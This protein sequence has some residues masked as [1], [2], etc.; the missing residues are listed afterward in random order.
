[1]NISAKGTLWA[2]QI[3]AMIYSIF[4]Q[5]TWF[6]IW[7]GDPRLGY[8]LAIAIDTGILAGIKVSKRDIQASVRPLHLVF[9]FCAVSW[10]ANIQASLYDRLN[11]QVPTFDDWSRLASQDPTTLV[12]VVFI[13]GIAPLIALALAY[14]HQQ[15]ERAR[16]AEQGKTV[17]GPPQQPLSAAPAFE[18]VAPHNLPLDRRGAIRAILSA[19]PTIH[20]A[21]L[22][23][24]VGASPSSVLW[25]AREAGFKRNPETGLWQRS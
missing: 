16:E 7:A 8:L 4:G 13:T 17:Q 22:A 18:V 1:M 25:D 24:R 15:E 19:E 23:E 10:L 9:A 3:L 5:A 6:G 21:A 14:L 20:P 2:G 12:N 11:H